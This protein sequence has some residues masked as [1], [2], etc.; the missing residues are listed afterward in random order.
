MILGPRHNFFLGLITRKLSF[1]NVPITTTI[2]RPHFILESTALPF[3]VL[4]RTEAVRARAVLAKGLDMGKLAALNLAVTSISAGRHLR[5]LEWA[6]GIRTVG[7]EFA[8]LLVLVGTPGRG[9]WMFCDAF[10][11][12]ASCAIAAH[13][14]DIYCDA[15]RGCW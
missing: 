8:L 2:G 11:V 4:V 15:R 14:V 3:L 1:A 7:K 5:V 10:E 12:F 9:R 6:L 13:I